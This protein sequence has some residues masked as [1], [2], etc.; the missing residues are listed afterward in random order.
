[1][2]Y[3]VIATGSKDGNCVLI[4]NVMVDCGVSYNKI[5]P[6]LYDVKYLLLTH[7]HTDH[8]RRSTLEY[9]KKNFPKIVIIGNYEVHQVFGV[10]IIAN[11]T[12]PISIGQYDFKAFECVHD[13]TCFGYTWQFEGKDILYA[14]DTSS[15][16]NAPDQKFDYFFLESNHDEYKVE[17]I[18]ESRDQFGYDAYS[19][20]KRH[21]STQKAKAFYY[22][23]RKD[24][25]SLFIE[26]HQSSRFY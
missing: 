17:K 18:L 6:L 25:D 24:R 22:T 11:T 1:M 19:G 5:R 14:T 10:D 15:M 9:I 3:E 26:L 12:F 2:Y 23:H 21:L 20:A 13:V 7:I 16:E 4:N 8:I